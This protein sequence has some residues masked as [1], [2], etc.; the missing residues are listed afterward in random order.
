MRILA[1]A[2]VASMVFVVGVAEIASARNEGNG[3]PGDSA[4]IAG[5]LECF[6]NA[7]GASLSLSLGSEGGGI[8]GVPGGSF[9]VF[10]ERTGTCAEAVAAL[11]GQ[12]P[13]P[14]CSEGPTAFGGEGFAFVCS[15]K[16]RSVVAA[17]GEL[18]KIVVSP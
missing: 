4:M 14:L 2:F 3:P 11:A 13:S 9:S 6:S 8:V 15:G 12:L 17:I 16:A 10:S 7:L 1:F 5:S 18:A